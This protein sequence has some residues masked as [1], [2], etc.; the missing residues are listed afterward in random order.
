LLQ[1]VLLAATV[2]C[3]I[4]VAWSQTATTGVLRG[5]ITDPSGGVIPNADVQATSRETGARREV[6]SG[7]DG[8]YVVPLLTPGTYRIEVAAEGFARAIQ[9]GAVISV[10]ETT[11]LNVRLKVGAASET[12]EVRGAPPIV[13][14][15]TNTLGE[16]VS[17]SQVQSLPLVNR[18]FTQIM[19]LSSGVVSSVTRAD[20]LGRGSGGVVSAPGRAT[21]IFK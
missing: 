17:P 1:T 9:S 6:K 5:T 13:D 4:P 16:V 7:A 12:I 20:E 3:V 8:T 2:L 11:V 19:D 15:T 18:N 10:T 14:T 21:T